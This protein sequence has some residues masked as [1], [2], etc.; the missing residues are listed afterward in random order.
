M[1]ATTTPVVSNTIV[2][3][4]ITIVSHHHHHRSHLDHNRSQLKSD[5]GIL[6]AQ[7]ISPDPAV[8]ITSRSLRGAS[9]APRDPLEGFTPIIIYNK[10]KILTYNES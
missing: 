6:V 2:A 10:L 7:F 5:L 1:A 4:S 3:T 8:F 9:H